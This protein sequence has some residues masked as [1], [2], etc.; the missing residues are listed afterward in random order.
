MGKREATAVEVLK[1]GGFFRKALESTYMGEK[2][3]TRLKTAT[4]GTVSGV[5]AATF[6]KLWAEGK[7]ASRPCSKS[8]TFPSEYAW[9][10]EA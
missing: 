7:L 9:K 10:G 1:A 2:F 6:Q 5:G 8:S 4:G 3:V